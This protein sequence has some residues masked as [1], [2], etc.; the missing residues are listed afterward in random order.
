MRLLQFAYSPFAA[1]VRKVLEL[2][3]L[4]FE[5]VNVPYLDR[6]ELVALTGG[7]LHI[8]VLEDGARVLDESARITAYLDETYEP[9]LREDPLS[10]VLEGWADNVLEDVAFR[11]GSPGV[12]DRFAGLEGGRQDAPAFFR[13]VKE[14][15]WGPG[16]IDAWRASER[17]LADRVVALLRPIGQSLAGR[18]FVLGKRASVADAAIYGQLFMVEIGLPGFVE[19]ELP[20]LAG[21][22][23]RVAAERLHGS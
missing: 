12:L 10:V 2:K 19:R 11:L 6:R 20:A 14:R 13:L 1:K 4:E 17:A 3:G 15:R 9:S 7:T 21:W 23:R 16:C 18:P 22:Y 8:P 5:L